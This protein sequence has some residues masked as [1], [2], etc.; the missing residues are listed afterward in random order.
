[1]EQRQHSGA[2]TMMK[3]MFRHGENGD[4][5]SDDYQLFLSEEIKNF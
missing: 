1:M 4:S 3:T 2:S 5:D